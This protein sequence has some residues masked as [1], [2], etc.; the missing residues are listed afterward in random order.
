MSPQ[1]RSNSRNRNDCGWL[2]GSNENITS[3]LLFTLW[4]WHIRKMRFLICTIWQDFFTFLK[5]SMKNESGHK[6]QNENSN[7]KLLSSQEEHHWIKLW[8]QVLFTEINRLGFIKFYFVKNTKIIVN[9]VKYETNVFIKINKIPKNNS[10]KISS[11]S[12][13]SR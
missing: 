3:K 4:R 6:H 1:K 5:C 12:A 9:V 8:I 11:L 13:R 7:Y 2:P 10:P